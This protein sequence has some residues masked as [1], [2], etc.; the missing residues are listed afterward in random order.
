VAILS[1][2]QFVAILSV[3]H[4]NTLLPDGFIAEIEISK[5]NTGKN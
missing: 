5:I 2:A 1:S 4:F 3:T